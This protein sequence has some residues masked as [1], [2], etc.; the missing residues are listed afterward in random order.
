VDKLLA[1]AL[2]ENSLQTDK[3]DLLDK[4]ERLKSLG[5]TSAKDVQQAMAERQRLKHLELENENRKLLA[6]A[7][8]HFQHKYPSYKFITEESVKRI[9]EKYGLVYGS[10][11]RYT[12][13]I[14][15]VNLKKME[16]FK[17]KQEDECWKQS[18]INIFPFGGAMW[19]TANERRMAVNTKNMSQHE[20]NKLIARNSTRMTPIRV[21]HSV[22][23]NHMSDVLEEITKCPLEIAAPQK[24]FN[25]TGM[26]VIDGQLVEILDPVVL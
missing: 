13:D 4:G 24:D 5:F 9:C 6:R 26:E 20:A 15:E 10:C 3:Q 7:I 23:F 17:I 21:G 8:N 12:G 11:D 2:T 18:I 19:F 1:L 14:P 22:S 25:M 16:E